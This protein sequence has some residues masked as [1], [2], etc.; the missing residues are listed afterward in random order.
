VTTPDVPLRMELTFE[1][2]GTAE[3]VWDA[4][5]TA[6]GISSWFVRTDLEEREGGQIVMHMGPDAESPGTVT[7]WD[8]PRQLRYEEPDWA[9]FSGHEGAV[10]PLVTEFLVEAR[11]GGTC[12]LRVVSSAFGTGADWEQ[13]FFDEMEKGWQPFFERLRLLLTYFPGQRVSLLEAQVTANGEPRAVVAAMCAELGIDQVGQPVTARGLTGIVEDLADDHV[14][15]RL[16]DPVP[17]FLAFYSYDQIAPAFSMGEGTCVAAVQGQLFS[18]AAPE[19]VQRE[20]PGWQAW[21]EELTIRS[22]LSRTAAAR[23]RR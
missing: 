5:A 10:T 19:L 8:P 11:S 13:E 9:A 7:G 21:L 1:L 23:A 6:N 20:Q 3:Q 22:F 15:L 16:S 17:G 4:I 18:D 14:L 12:V 2:P